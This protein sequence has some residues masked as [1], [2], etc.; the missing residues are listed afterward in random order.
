MPPEET[1]LG[2]LLQPLI[3]VLEIALQIIST[4]QLEERRPVLRMK[5]NGRLQLVDSLHQILIQNSPNVIFE[6]AA[7][8]WRPADVIEFGRRR[9]R[10]HFLQELKC[11]RHAERDHI[12]QLAFGSDLPCAAA[13]HI[14]DAGSNLKVIRSS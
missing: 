7:W 2:N 13:F 10:D 4:A 8:S 11:D 12:L 5:T 9:V 3:R 14:G 6:C 1:R